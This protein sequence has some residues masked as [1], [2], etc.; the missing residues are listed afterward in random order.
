MY[1]AIKYLIKKKF[2]ISIKLNVRAI[3]SNRKVE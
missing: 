2:L 3:A 1:Y